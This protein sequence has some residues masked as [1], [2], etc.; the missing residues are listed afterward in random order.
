MPDI[1]QVFFVW[2]NAFAKTANAHSAAIVSLCSRWLVELEEVLYGPPDRRLRETD[3]SD[4][5]S[6]GADLATNL[7]LTIARSASTYP[8]PMRELYER[9]VLSADTRRAPTPS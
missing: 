3:W 4:L 9:A 2:Q 8:G 5:D 7:R 6:N 1:V